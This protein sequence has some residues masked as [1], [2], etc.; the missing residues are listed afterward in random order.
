MKIKIALKPHLMAN[1]MLMNVSAHL[2][3][4]VKK[5]KVGGA[6]LYLLLFFLKLIL[7]QLTK[8]NTCDTPGD[9]SC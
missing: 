2:D 1:G 8:F 4:F 7:Y 3:L 6:K 9:N 5:T